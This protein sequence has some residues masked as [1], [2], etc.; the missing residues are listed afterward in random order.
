V[1]E[2]TAL[3]SEAVVR[4]KTDLASG[5]G[6]LISS[7]G[8]IL[9]NN[10]MVSD[11]KEITVYL[12]NGSKYTATVKGRDLVRDIALIKIEANGLKFLEIGNPIE[13]DLGQQVVVLGYPLAGE[14]VSV[15]SGIISTIDFDDGRNITWLQTDSAINPGNSGGPMLNMKGQVVG[16]VSAKMVGVAVEGIGFTISANTV[17]VYLSRLKN[18]EIIRSY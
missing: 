14:N 8:Y 1:Q 13:V 2:V 16:I 11:A 4:I 15:T 3:A 5:S 9:T 10:H 6:F 7:D 18:G 12:K 17:N